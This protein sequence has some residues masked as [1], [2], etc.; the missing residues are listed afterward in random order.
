MAQS[1]VFS[2][3]ADLREMDA[4]LKNTK[5]LANSTF[6]DFLK[7]V[8]KTNK[9]EKE[10]EATLSRQAKEIKPLRDELNA[11]NDEKVKNGRLT[12]EQTKRYKELDT[13]VS[14]LEKKYKIE[15]KS[16]KE[17]ITA[18]NRKASSQKKLHGSLKASE[19][20]LNRTKRAMDKE[21]EATK[22]NTSAMRKGQAVRNSGINDLVRHVRRVETLVVAYYALSRGIDNL[23][24][25]GVMLNKTVEDGKIGIGALITA[26][27]T[28]EGESEKTRFQAS[29]AKSAETILKIKKASIETSATFPELTSVFQTAIGKAFGAGEAMGATV[30]EQIGNTIK[31]SQRLTNIAGATG[32]EMFKVNQEIRA[33][34]SGDITKDA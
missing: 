28:L 4:Q 19:R 32:M 20:E 1:T 29:M 9:A 34:L 22:R 23:A 13:A 3:K 25:K 7:S 33:M 14:S 27:T 21:T 8:E 15:N 16:L 30:D 11:L 31:L 5:D 10:L 17:N 2:F 18:I 26:N 6:N 24:T 12:K